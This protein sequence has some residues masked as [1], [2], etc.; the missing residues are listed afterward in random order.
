M[1]CPPQVSLRNLVN[2]QL[3]SGLIRPPKKLPQRTDLVIRRKA[4]PPAY[5]VVGQ[6]LVELLYKLYPFQQ[7]IP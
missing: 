3:A 5:K 4:A 2:A 6:T 7:R 1:L